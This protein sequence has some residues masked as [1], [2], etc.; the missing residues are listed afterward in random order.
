MELFSLKENSELNI[1][2]LNQEIKNAYHTDYFHYINYDIINENNKQYLNISIKENPNK[3]AKLGVLWDNHYKLIGKLKLNILNKPKNRFRIQNELL[4]SGIKSNKLSIYYHFHNKININLMPFISLKNAIMHIGLN[5]IDNELYFLKHDSYITSFGA[6]VPFDNYGFIYLSQN[7]MD[8]TYSSEEFNLTSNNYKFYNAILDIDQLDNL[9]IPKA[10]FRILADYQFY[11]RNNNFNYINMKLEYY[12][13]FDYNHTLR[14]SSWYKELSND[15]PLY[16]QSS[17]G[18]YNWAAG[19]DEFVLSGT[20]LKLLI[21]EYQY[22]YKNSTT[23]TVITNKL[24]KINNIK[25]GPINWGLG[26]K[27]KSIVGPFNFIWGRGH[28]NPFNKKSKKHNIFY[29]NFGVEI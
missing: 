20:N 13:T 9:S 7:I 4:F 17:Y 22:H 11:N 26:I 23:F 16:L 15:A 24:I 21:A 25:N 29:F 6:I 10:G 3:Q 27:V 14:L 12:K 8:N 5:N 28:T 1:S 19:Y 18:G 2:K